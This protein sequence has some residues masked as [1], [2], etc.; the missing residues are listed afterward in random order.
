M[1][2]TDDQVQALRPDALTPAQIATKAIAV[3]ETKAGLPLLKAF[4]L[5]VLAGMFIGLGGT[6]MLVVKAD[7]ELSFG[8]SQLLSGLVFSVGL[9]FVV[10][11]G[12]ELFTGNSLMV[13]GALEGK[14]SLGKMLAAWI[15]VYLG[16]LCGSLLLAFLLHGAN[17]AGM[18]GGAVGEAAVAVGIAKANLP[19]SVI[20]FRAILCNVLVCLGVWMSFAARTVVDKLAACV[21]AVVPFVAC[22]FEHCVA[23]MFFL[24][25]AM[26]SSTGGESVS[27]AGAV[28]N[29]ACATAGNIVGGA[30]LVGCVYWAIYL[31]KES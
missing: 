7:A 15:V 23:N 6:F 17:Y 26:L 25:F 28:E 12:A 4:L 5:A 11:A 21:M 19:D 31:R 14:Y 13:I 29:I 20:F 27:M 8:V 18:G 16:N 30:L 3:G 1:A 10:T 2:L 22:G 9:F 24:P